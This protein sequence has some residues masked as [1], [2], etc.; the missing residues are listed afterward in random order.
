MMKG[1]EYLR[2]DGKRRI[3]TVSFAFKI[4]I[5]YPSVSAFSR[6]QETH[7]LLSDD[8]L[9]QF[10][11]RIRTFPAITTA[12][13]AVRH[14]YHYMFLVPRNC[15]M[16]RRESLV[17]L[18][19][20]QSPSHLPSCGAHVA[21]LGSKL[22]AKG[23]LRHPAGGRWDFS[24]P[25]SSLSDVSKGEV[26]NLKDTLCPDWSEVFWVSLWS[27]TL[28]QAGE[29]RIPLEDDVQCWQSTVT[30]WDAIVLSLDTR[31]LNT[32]G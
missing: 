21:Y 24:I 6:S 18:E 17:P 27:G 31:T 4:W 8:Y 30:F 14:Y 10:S 16:M 7:K 23:R 2:C 11:L 12:A 5:F 15:L 32:S 9:S 20:L 25:W 26:G 28:R 19:R 29:S 22:E 1:F 13:C 3:D